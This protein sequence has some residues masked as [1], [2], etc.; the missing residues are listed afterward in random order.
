MGVRDRR[1]ARRV[2]VGMGRE[3]P[4]RSCP[5][6]RR[7]RPR[8][9][10][11][12]SADL[13]RA[14][15]PRMERDPLRHRGRADA[16]VGAPHPPHGRPNR[17]PLSRL[18]IARVPRVL[19]RLARPRPGDDHGCGRP[20]RSRVSLA[21]IG[22]RN[23]LP[24]VVAIP[25]ARVLGRLRGQRAR[26]RVPARGHRGSATSPSVGPRS[27]R[28]RTATGRNPKSWRAR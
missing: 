12:R 28:C 9:R 22:L 4:H 11:E 15:A 3:S 10:A 17:D 18:R 24:R 23:P 25:R 26:L 21:R 13:P 5:R 27:R 20:P 1:R 7:R 19:S 16:L 6:A 14:P 8:R 2:A